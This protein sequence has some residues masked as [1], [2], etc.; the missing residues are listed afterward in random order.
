M[1]YHTESDN[2]YQDSYTPVFFLPCLL[3]N[4]QKCRLLQLIVHGKVA[5]R[6]LMPMVWEE[7]RLLGLLQ[8]FKRTAAL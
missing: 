1:D 3:L 7:H 6:W 5:G 8:T 2:Q 4:T